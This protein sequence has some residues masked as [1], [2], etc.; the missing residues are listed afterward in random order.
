MGFATADLCDQHE[1]DIRSGQLRVVTPMFRAFGARKSFSGQIATL[2]LFED[3]SFVRKTLEQP[4]QGRVLVIDGGGSLR[5]ALVGDQLAIL[6][7]KNG[8]NGIV[9]YG[10]IRDSGAIADMDIGVLAL[11]AHPQKTDKKNVGEAELAVTF[12]GVTFRPGEWLYAD[13]DG[14]LV[15]VSELT[16]P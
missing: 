3:N 2:K 11:G 7:A 6:G 10:C 9:V 15:S 4:G 8:W 1:E 12:G 14:I 5:R 13:E 16:Q